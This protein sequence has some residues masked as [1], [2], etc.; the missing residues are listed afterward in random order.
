MTG[1]EPRYVGAVRNSR[2]P[3]ISTFYS[4]AGGDIL[5]GDA[6]KTKRILREVPQSLRETR[7]YATSHSCTTQT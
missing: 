6:G 5:P 7:L 1:Q 2:S 3:D 4:S